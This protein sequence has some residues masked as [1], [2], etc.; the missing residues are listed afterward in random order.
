MNNAHAY[1]EQFADCAV[2][3]ADLLV[4]E[5]ANKFYFVA[6]TRDYNLLGKEMAIY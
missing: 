3:D 1:L 4:E 2:S 6:E 5:C